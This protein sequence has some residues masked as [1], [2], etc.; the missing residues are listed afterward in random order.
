MVP[1]SFAAFWY[2]SAFTNSYSIFSKRESMPPVALFLLYANSRALPS[3]P[4]ALEKW[5]ASSSAMTCF[6]FLLG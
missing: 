1:L 4:K 3:L 5:A 6:K 2:V